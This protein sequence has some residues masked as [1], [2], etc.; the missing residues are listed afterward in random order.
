MKLPGTPLIASVSHEVQTYEWRVK[1]LTPPRNQLR[2]GLGATLANRMEREHVEYGERLEYR[3]AGKGKFTY[4][5]PPGCQGDLSCI[6]AEMM[7]TNT[8]PV[9]ELG[10]RFAR[11]I[12][13][14]QLSL[15]PYLRSR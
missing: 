15:A 9:R 4:R 12:R 6:Y 5:A 13:T 7:S 14:Q 10:E 2:Y 1:S 8:Q 3:R 11:F